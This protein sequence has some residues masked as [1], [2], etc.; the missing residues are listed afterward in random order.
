[1]SEYDGINWDRMASLLNNDKWSD[2]RDV[3]GEQ[4]KIIKDLKSKIERLREA[5]GGVRGLLEPY[6]IQHFEVTQTMYA[7]WW[8][9]IGEILDADDEA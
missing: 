9:K 5:L 1:M 8:H 2:W 6:P 3:V 7:D 4:E